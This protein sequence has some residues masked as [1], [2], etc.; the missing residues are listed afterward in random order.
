M[1][2]IFDKNDG[3]MSHRRSNEGDLK[4]RYD[5]YYTLAHK[6]YCEAKMIMIKRKVDPDRT[7]M[8]YMQDQVLNMN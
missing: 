1:V 2:K 8:S 5:Y 6:V 4:M 7:M 3:F